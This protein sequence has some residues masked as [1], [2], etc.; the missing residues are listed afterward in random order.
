MRAQGTSSGGSN[1]TGGTA[2]RW[3]RRWA[4]SDHHGEHVAA[5]AGKWCIEYRWHALRE[6]QHLWCY[7]TGSWA[8]SWVRR[9]ASRCACGSEGGSMSASSTGGTRSGSGNATGQ[10]VSRCTYK[11][12]S[13]THGL[14]HCRPC[15]LALLVSHPAH[16]TPEL[17]AIPCNSPPTPCHPTLPIA[18]PCLATQLVPRHPFHHPPLPHTLTGKQISPA[19]PLSSLVAFRPSVPQAKPLPTPCPHPCSSLNSN[20]SHPSLPPCTHPSRCCMPPPPY[21]KVQSSQPLLPPRPP[22]RALSPPSSTGT[23][24]T[25]IAALPVRVGQAARYKD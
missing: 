5:R 20:L 14:S 17:P 10:G 11:P 2:Q 12:Y 21:P 23:A 3:V 1:S 18:H 15:F 22:S 13:Y 25:G 24:V 6:Q 4:S 16:A 9:W 19:P 8:R 7:T